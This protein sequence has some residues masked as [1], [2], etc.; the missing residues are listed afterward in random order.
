[1]DGAPG[2]KSRLK[3]APRIVLLTLAFATLRAQSV[4]AAAPPPDPNAR[5]P[6]S[7][8]SAPAGQDARVQPGS[9][10]LSPGERIKSEQ[11][12]AGPPGTDQKAR[13]HNDADP[14]YR[15]YDLTHVQLRMRFDLHNQWV[16]GSTTFLIRSLRPGLD[17]LL[18]DLVDTLRVTA[19]TRDG[20]PVR[21][22]HADRQLSLFLSPPLALAETTRVTVAYEGYPPFDGFMGL[23]FDHHHDPQNGYPVPQPLISTMSET[24]SAPAW[25]PCKD[26]TYDKFTCETFFSVPDSLY[27]VSN[28]TL[29]EV[30]P[31]ADGFHTFHWSEANPI[32]TYLVSLAATNYVSWSDQYV[33]LDSSRVMPV[34]YFAYPESESKAR[35]AWART[36]QMISTFA[37]LFGEYPFLDE[38]YAMAEY[39]WGGAMENQTATSY[40]EYFLQ[41]DVPSN[42]WTVAHELAHQWWG[43]QVTIGSW[44]DIW[45]NEGFASYCEALWLE[46]DGGFPAYQAHMQI[47]YQDSFN[48]P[49]V[50]PVYYFSPETYFKGAWVLHMLRWVVGDDLFFRGLRQYRQTFTDRPAS[51]VGFRQVMER[52]SGRDLVHFFQSWVYGTGMPFYEV[53]WTW[54]PQKDGSA[55]VH[56][57][58]VQSQTEPVF[59]M[60]AELAFDFPDGRTESRVVQDSLRDQGFTFTF[61]AAPTQVRFDPSDWILKHLTY[62]S[63]PAGAEE[64]MT[65]GSRLTSALGWTLSPA[66]PNPCRNLTRLELRPAPGAASGPGSGLD[67]PGIYLSDLSGR[68]LNKLEP[69]RGANQAFLQ[70][71]GRLADGRL[72]PA[73][74]Y[75]IGGKSSGGPRPVRVILVR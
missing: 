16:S 64:G 1:M 7:E 22:A 75:W 46:H 32:A 30:I 3:G 58:V 67:L 61:P 74:V 14:R 13:A 48:G 26:V 52:V 33:S 47:F 28:G 25:W 42:E 31:E 69:V 19:V 20:R 5:R 39:N 73:G 11:A 59:A 71:N 23:S 36:P 15:D 44:D 72:A 68:L 57:Q 21:Y 66:Q 43:D 63:E 70:W 49:I 27:A 8:Y 51:T 41:Y 62:G 53:G 24:N 55:L 29:V 37:R 54:A 2:R 50:P 34:A 40:G 18:L 38:K 65:P 56:V 9:R 10:T 60:P 12:R 4:P 17:E 45:L 35:A 6:A